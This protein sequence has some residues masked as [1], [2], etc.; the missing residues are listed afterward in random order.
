MNHQ[1]H[2]LELAGVDI[3]TVNKEALVDVSALVFDTDIPIEQRAAHML[4]TV[5]NPYCFRVGD[6]GV[7]L[8]FP[9]NAPSLQDFLID[10][11]QRKKGGL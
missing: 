7:K 4:H 9:E 2:I 6:M 8:E 10:F 3:V 5:K 11:L 1:M